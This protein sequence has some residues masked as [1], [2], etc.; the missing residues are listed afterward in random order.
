M[1]REFGAVADLHVAPS[2]STKPDMDIP[3][4]GGA[5]LPCSIRRIPL[6]N[7]CTEKE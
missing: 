4:R 5:L 7:D 1:A 6:N 2:E 3:H